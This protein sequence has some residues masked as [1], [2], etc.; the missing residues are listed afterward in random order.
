[1]RHGL[2]CGSV[3]GSIH[4]AGSVDVDVGE[5]LLQV[6]EVDTAVGIITVA[7]AGA[8]HGC[9]GATRG[10]VAVSLLLFD[11]DVGVTVHVLFITLPVFEFTHVFDILF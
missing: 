10:D 3:C 4:G 6:R 8:V 9:H 7:I 11:L 5:L 1:L 2:V